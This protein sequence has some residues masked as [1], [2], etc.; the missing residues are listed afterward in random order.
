LVG[1]FLCC[2]TLIDE[3]DNTHIGYPRVRLETYLAG[4]AVA[5]AHLDMGNTHLTGGTGDFFSPIIRTKSRII[6]ITEIMAAIRILVIRQ[7]EPLTVN[8]VR[9]AP[10]CRGDRFFFS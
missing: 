10:S 6:G 1:G 4:A 9:C 8:A 5:V 7:D 2:R 3:I